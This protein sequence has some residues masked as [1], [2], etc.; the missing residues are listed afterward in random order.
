MCNYH[1]TRVLKG[2]GKCE[3]TNADYCGS[4]SECRAKH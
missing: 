2:G 4:C 3:E 1:Y